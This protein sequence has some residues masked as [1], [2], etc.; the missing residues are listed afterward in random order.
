MKRWSV[1]LLSFWVIL[2][3]C[4]PSFSQESL[5]ITTYYPSPYG[6]Y[7]ELTAHRMKIGT[8]YSGA[9]TTVAD[10][11]L[12]VEGN[13]GIG[14]ASPQA[15]LDVNGRIRAREGSFIYSCPTYICPSCNGDCNGQL[16]TSPTCTEC[17]DGD[18]GSCGSPRPC[19][20][21]GRLVAP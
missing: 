20:L 1:S 18:R 2:C 5:T 8:T 14:T 16:T 9:G 4:G 17:Y 7:R 13:V 12:I 11:N 6:S 19:T 10:N 3:F 21:V 15:K